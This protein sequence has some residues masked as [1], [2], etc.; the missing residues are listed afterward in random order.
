MGSPW[1]FPPADQKQSSGPIA[2][3]NDAGQIEQQMAGKEVRGRQESGAKGPAYVWCFGI[4]HDARVRQRYA[5][6]AQDVESL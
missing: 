6:P 4:G 5:W 3:S 2:I 1:F